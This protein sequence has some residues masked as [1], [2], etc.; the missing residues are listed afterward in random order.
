MF[1]D[2]HQSERSYHG[3]AVMNSKS[4]GSPGKGRHLSTGNLVKHWKGTDESCSSL[5]T[6]CVPG[7]CIRTRRRARGDHH[8]SGL[9]QGPRTVDTRF[10]SCGAW[11]LEEPGA[12]P[13][14]PMFLCSSKSVRTRETRFSQRLEMY[15]EGCRRASTIVLTVDLRR[16]ELKLEQ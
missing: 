13:S 5:S 15:L 16:I 10:S 1:L 4:Y 3:H 8:T 2:P 7:R 14:V 11:V 6:R 9:H 12:D